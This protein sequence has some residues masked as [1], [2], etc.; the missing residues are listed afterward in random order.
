MA[1]RKPQTP[2]ARASVLQISAVVGFFVIFIAAPDSV[3]LPLILAWV[4]GAAG[5]E[6]FVR[7][8]KCGKSLLMKGMFSVAWP[9]K[10]CRRC[11]TDLTIVHE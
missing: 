11:G 1:F 7:C 2:F 5:L 10:Q 9:A 8:P 4:L 6:L 3:E